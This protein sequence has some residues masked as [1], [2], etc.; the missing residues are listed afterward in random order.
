[1]AS[2]ILLRNV[3]EDD[4]LIFY[5]QQLDP[6]ATDMAAFPAR[7]REP[8]LA[9]WQKIMADESVTLRT[10]LFH[11]KVVGN[12]VGFERAGER[13]VGYWI[14]REYWGKGV[15]SAALRQFLVEVKSRP[16]YAH[17]AKHN[18]ASRR[19]LE[20][21]GFTLLREDKGYSTEPGVE[22]EEY[23]LVLER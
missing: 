4:L 18:V 1:M 15:A 22:I 3:I 23:V 20:K 16:L 2:D 17:V 21:C 7:H 13:E 8:F 12:I 14:G 11:G 9:H 19:V 10:I 6:V 5:E